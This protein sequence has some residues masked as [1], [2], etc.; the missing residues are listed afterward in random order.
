MAWGYDDNSIVR[1][2]GTAY[3]AGIRNTFFT[4]DFKNDFALVYM[5]QVNPFNDMN[6]YNL[7][8][9][10]ERLIYEDINNVN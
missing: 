4:I 6:A 9:S 5:T 2:V 7:F 8:T 10:F 3:W 1:P